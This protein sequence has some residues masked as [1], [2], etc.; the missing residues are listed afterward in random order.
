MKKTKI[1][2]FIGILL[3]VIVFFR[4]FKRKKGMPQPVKNFVPE[5]YLGKWYEIARYNHIFERNLNKVTANYS[6]L[7]DGRI[8]VLN[9]GYNSKN[10][11]RKIAEGIAEFAGSKKVGHLKVSFFWPFS[12]DYFVLELDPDYRWAIVGSSSKKY[13]W[14]L[15]R[16]PELSKELKDSLMIK[17]LNLGF[18]SNKIIWVEQ[19]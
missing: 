15:S 14:L 19:E 17:I 16:T 1:F 8:K 9:S 2:L 4:L 10:G 3:G 7:P 6:L 5:K 11:E 13:F 12:A 18:D